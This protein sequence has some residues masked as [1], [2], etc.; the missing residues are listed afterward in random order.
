MTRIL[1]S[2]LNGTILLL[3]GLIAISIQGSLFSSWPLN[4]IKPD[5]ILWLVLWFA[6]RR[7]FIEGGILTL[8]LAYFEELHSAAP[9]GILLAK[10]LFVYLAT[11]GANQVLVIPNFESYS[12]VTGVM[13]ALS[14]W[15][16]LLLLALLGVFADSGTGWGWKGALILTLPQAAIQA[17]L[18]I[19]VYPALERFD[20]LTYKQARPEMELF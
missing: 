12:M 11:A 10:Y 7:S 20:L 1:L 5:S 13:S 4:Y 16:Q 6:L 17:G 19:W 3:L 9:S 15:F 8:I 2:R 14:Q 18:S